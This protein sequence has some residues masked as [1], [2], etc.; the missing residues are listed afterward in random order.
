MFNRVMTVLFLAA[1]VA[2]FVVGQETLPAPEPQRSDAVGSLFS[3]L[4]EKFATVMKRLDDQDKD[5][6]AILALL[7][8][9]NVMTGPITDA[10]ERMVTKNHSETITVMEGFRDLLKDK[11]VQEQDQYKGILDRFKDREDQESARYHGILSKLDDLRN[12]EP[13]EPLFPVINATRDEMRKSFSA[14]A[15]ELS[16]FTSIG[17]RMENF[18]NRMVW[19]AFLFVLTVILGLTG[20]G[21]IIA[22]GVRQYKR[23]VDAIMGVPNKIIQIG[24]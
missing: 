18:A 19:I 15:K 17:D 14:Q 13:G 1:V 8:E 16:K 21:L 6:D 10:L 24:G 4:D 11:T 2:T 23:A 7:A 20:F 22:F 3:D 5:L 9:K 12:R